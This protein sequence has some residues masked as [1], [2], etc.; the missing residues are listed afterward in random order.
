MKSNYFTIIFFCLVFLLLSCS[1][2]NFVRKNE[3]FRNL[4]YPEELEAGFSKG[5][6]L[7]ENTAGESFDNTDYAYL[8]DKY[9]DENSMVDYIGIE[10]EENMLDRYI[11]DI[12][13]ADY[14]NLS[15]YEKLSLLINSYNA[16]TLKLIIQNPGIDSI[17]DIPSGKR[18][19]N[20]VWDIAG[21]KVT[22][23]DLE[24]KRIR[25]EFGEPKIHFAL[26]CASTS[27]P[28]LRKVPFEGNKLKEQLDDQARQFFSV[29]RNFKWSP[30]KKELYLSEI[31]DWFRFDFAETEMGVVDYSLKYI[32]T[33]KADEIESVRD[34][35][36]IKY[37]SYDWSLNGNWK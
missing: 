1:P 17:K 21:E 34:S 22:L 15:R 26:V 23:S 18:W 25:G 11:E 27:C 37:V 31:L 13:K 8:L 16:F 35:I 20:N 9:V 14:E 36:K 4:F 12:A 19:D 29:K 30:D 7:G 33:E 10:T 28:Q 32:D 3:F 6:G 24:H 5:D 2:R